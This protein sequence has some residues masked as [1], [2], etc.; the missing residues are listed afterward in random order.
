MWNSHNLPHYV[1]FWGNLPPPQRGHHIWMPPKHSFF[2]EM[3]VSSRK[4]LNA[5]DSDLVCTGPRKKTFPRLRVFLPAVAWVVLSKTG[6][7]FCGTL[8][9]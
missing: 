8:Y 9:V 5:F 7:L 4:R 1:C 6:K 3:P 2:I